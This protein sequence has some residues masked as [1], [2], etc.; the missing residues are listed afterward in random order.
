MQEYVLGRYFLD[1]YESFC[2][3]LE[4]KLEGLGKISGS[5]AWQY[6][7]YY[8]TYKQDKNKHYRFMSKWGDSIR[9]SFE[10]VKS[11]IAQ[12]L[13]AGKNEDLEKIAANRIADKLKG[14]I[15]S[16]YFPERFLNIF[17]ADYLNDVLV[18][19]NLDNDGIFN[20]A[21]IYKQEKLLHF[22][23]QD[24]VMKK[25]TVD[26]FA[27]FI[28]DEMT[29]NFYSTNTSNPE[30]EDF[31]NPKFPSLSEI[32]IEEVNF[33]LTTSP[34]EAKPPVKWKGNMERK[35]RLL[36]KLGTRGELIVIEFEKKQLINANR[37]DLANKIVHIAKDDDSAGY[38]IKSFDVN[39]NEKLIEV[40]ATKLPPGRAQ[41]FISINEKEVAEKSNNYCIYIVHGVTSKTP[42]IWNISNPFKPLNNK[43]RLKPVTFS[44]NV[45]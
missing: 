36:K 3:W 7:V 44:V 24:K 4:K 2:Y 26:E 25:W 30:L 23:K 43:L 14:K 21:S 22:K 1:D 18:H 45:N 5:P 34:D 13:K 20:T 31:T 40:K 16:T 28:N 9:E 17:S 35:N 12:L 10:E 11:A 37:K 42:K 29:R 33:E 19:F 6:G 27:V 32:S 15:L 39:G 8:G 41:F 38:D